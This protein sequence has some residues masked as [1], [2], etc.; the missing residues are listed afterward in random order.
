[1]RKLFTACLVLVLLLAGC[2]GE[3]SGGPAAISPGAESGT[4]SEAQSDGSASDPGDVSNVEMIV[5]GCKGTYR[6]EINEA[7]QPHGI[8]TITF[9]SGTHKGNSYTGPFVDGRMQGNG[10]YK[11]S[12]GDEYHGYYLDDDFR[13]AGKYVFSNG[14]ELE[15]V[16]TDSANGEGVYTDPDGVRWSCELKDSHMTTYEQLGADEEWCPLSDSE[17]KDVDAI[18][19]SQVSLLESAGM[20]SIGFYSTYFYDATVYVFGPEFETMVDK[21]EN[22]T[23]TDADRESWDTLV[24]TT[25]QMAAQIDSAVKERYPNVP[26]EFCMQTESGTDGETLLRFVNGFLVDN[27]IWY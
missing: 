2:G 4:R 9:S 16:F 10:Y 5:E 22:G 23:L 17:V 19:D 27:I 7:G 12:N 24:D 6:G 3:S 26:T 20:D 18:I 8:G 14:A 11:F 15:G 1:M 21:V 25:G 13:G